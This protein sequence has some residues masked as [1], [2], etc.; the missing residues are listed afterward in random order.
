M[1]QPVSPFGVF[2]S[3]SPASAASG[4]SAPPMPPADLN[5][6]SLT[7]ASGAT[8]NFWIDAANKDL[9]RKVLTKTGTVDVRRHRLAD[10]YH[11]DLSV[12]PTTSIVGPVSRDA[13]INKRQWEHL[14]KM[15]AE[16]AKNDAAGL[17]FKLVADMA[18]T[19]AHP[20]LLPSV[21]SAITETIAGGIDASRGSSSADSNQKTDDETVQALIKAAK[22]GDMQS[23]ATLFR[24]QASLAGNVLAAS[25]PSVTMTPTSTTVTSVSS[26]TIPAPPAAALVTETAASDSA[27]L[28]GGSFSVEALERADGLRDVIAQIEGGEVARMRELYGPKPGRATNPMWALIKVTITRRERLGVEFNTEFG[29]NKDKFF[30]FFTYQVQPSGKKRKATATGT[31]TL[32]PSRLIVQAI[33]H[34]NKAL[35]VERLSEEYRE[36]GDFSQDLWEK[37]W[38]GQNKWEIWRSIGKEKY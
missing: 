4:A 16:W 32:R 22:D 31:E 17:P 38:D 2:P 8:L 20:T 9:P 5:F 30:S 6:A 21:Q 3:T 34:R 13:D 7:S 23:M 35:D 1:T 11:I 12:A 37:K 27:I 26:P 33:P 25:S 10:Y 36:N 28:A 29:G 15:G 24:L 18:H 19:G 14:R